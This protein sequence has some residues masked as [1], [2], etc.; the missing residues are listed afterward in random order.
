MTGTIQRSRQPAPSDVHPSRLPEVRAC[1]CGSTPCMFSSHAIE[2]DPYPM[3]IETTPT[4]RTRL[5]SVERSGASRSNSRMTNL[6]VRTMYQP[7][8]PNGRR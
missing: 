6:R 2:L 1:S 4:N 7:E 3:P 5:P 8:V